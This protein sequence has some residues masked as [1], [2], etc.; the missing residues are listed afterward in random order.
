MV[1]WKGGGGKIKGEDSRL[2]CL[3]WSEEDMHMESD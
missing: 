2:K 3:S 1:Q